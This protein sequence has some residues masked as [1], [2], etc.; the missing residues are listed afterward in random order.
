MEAIKRDSM[1][2]REEVDEERKMLQMAEVW[3]EERVFKE[4]WLRFGSRCS[5]DIFVVFEEVAL[6]KANEREIEPLCCI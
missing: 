5:D 3:R 1:K 4:V 6:A 2:L